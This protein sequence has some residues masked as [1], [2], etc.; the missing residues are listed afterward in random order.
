[1]FY[2]SIQ[3]FLNLKVM[4]HVFAVS[5]QAEKTAE[6][7]G[8]QRRCTGAHMSWLMKGSQISCRLVQRRTASSVNINFPWRGVLT[9]S[10]Q[11]LLNKVE[12]VTAEGH[13]QS[14]LG[15]KL[16]CFI[17]GPKKEG[18]Q[19]N[20]SRAIAHP[21]LLIWVIIDANVCKWVLIKTDC[22]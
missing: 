2:H 15:A 21:S 1:M 6:C 16:K 4:C 17:S 22:I 7:E 11:I 8:K 18:I 9:H 20:Q 13:R 5:Q 10:S 14:C 3:L 19:S 12:E